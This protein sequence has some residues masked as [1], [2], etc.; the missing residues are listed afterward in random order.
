MKL[1]T[2]IAL[3]YVALVAV[4][5]VAL[6]VYLNR[7]EQDRLREHVERDMASE[8]RLVALAVGPLLADGAPAAEVDAAAKRLGQQIEGGVTIIDSDGRALGDSDA[9]PTS[10]GDLSQ[11]PEVAQALSGELGKGS[12]YSEGLD[13]DV[14]Y[15]AVPILSGQDSVGV[16]RVSRLS[17]DISVSLS[18]I[19][20]TLLV[21]SLAAGSAAGL[22]ALVIGGTTAR[23]LGRLAQ[24][25]RRL[26]AGHLGERAPS[27]ATAE[28]ADLA[29]AFNAMAASF[30]GTISRLAE[31]RNRLESLLA[32]SADGVVAVDRDGSIT[33]TNAAVE[34]LFGVTRAEAVGKPFLHVVRDH[35]LNELAGRCAALGERGLRVIAYGPEQRWLQAS[36]VPI[37]GGGDWAGLIIL[38]DLSEVRRLDTV[39]RDFITNV[40]HEL[41]TPLAG[42]KA[43][44]ETLKE[45]ALRDPEAAAEFV[46]HIENETDRLAQMVEELLE[47]S[48]IESGAAPLRMDVVPVASLLERCVQRFAPQAERAGLSLSAEVVDGEKLAVR[49]DEDRLDQALGNLLH[50][51]IKFTSAGG[52]V[53]VSAAA[54]D[55][56]VA[57]AVRDTGIGISTD[58]Q[59]RI[60]ERF[61]KAAEAR[62]RPGSGLGLAIVKHIV[63]A[64][65]GRATVESRPG[66]G[67]T[68]TVVLPRAT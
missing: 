29:D 39:R 32:S 15:I 65:G 24:A 45:G 21:A 35:E 11:R 41:R 2:R 33:F 16:A 61:Y 40:S 43:S 37:E 51:A 56:E 66:Q 62:G 42:I 6:A 22:V 5:L 48:R 31:E 44:A 23:S 63:Q 36:A 64:H 17:S 7:S 8:A 14:T 54:R 12:G 47:L 53:T 50:N 3:A 67:S 9:S 59:T 25:A 60:F 68:F 58:D 27:A 52:Q 10:L 20:L 19:A 4:S 18:D 57:I 34:A 1:R 30:Q 38:H 46:R 55:G 26:A 13:G 49:G 28:V